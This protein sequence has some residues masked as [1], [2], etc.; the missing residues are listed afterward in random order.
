MDTDQTRSVLSGVFG[1]TA[2]NIQKT[3]FPIF[4]K[5]CKWVVC[6]FKAV[7]KQK[8]NAIEHFLTKSHSKQGLPPLLGIFGYF[9][10]STY[11]LIQE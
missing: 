3:V 5:A 4:I 1:I 10:K 2:T 8:D 7:T 11:Q 9:T 6:V